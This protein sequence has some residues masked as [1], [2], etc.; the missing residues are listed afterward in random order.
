M[1][2]FAYPD[3]FFGND[4]LGENEISLGEDGADVAGDVIGGERGA[5]VTEGVDSGVPVPRAAR[6]DAHLEI[7]VGV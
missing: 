3:V 7:G 5:D 1:R 6:I 2:S 4:G